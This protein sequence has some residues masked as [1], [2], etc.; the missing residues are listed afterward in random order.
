MWQSQTKDD[1]YQQFG[2]WLREVYPLYETAD[3]Q[4]TNPLFDLWTGPTQENGNDNEKEPDKILPIKSCMDISL[5]ET[6]EPDPG[7]LFVSSSDDECDKTITPTTVTADE[8]C[9]SGNKGKGPNMEFT[10]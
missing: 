9:T 5:S 8:P 4:F 1:V 3:Y 2:L 6:A 10:K 7:I